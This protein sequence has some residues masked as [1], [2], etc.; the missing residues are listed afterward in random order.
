[1]RGRER[2]ESQRERERERR[3]AR[4]RERERERFDSMMD[5]SI[6]VGKLLESEKHLNGHDS[7]IQDLEAFFHGP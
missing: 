7:W 3:R 2:E 5:D 1:M 6:T 4:A